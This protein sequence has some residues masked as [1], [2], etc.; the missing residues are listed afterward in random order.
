MKTNLYPVTIAGIGKYTPET[1]ITNN[2]LE[3]ILDTS[4]EWITTRS[5]IK[6]R[7]IVSGNETGA[8]LAVK[9]GREALEYAGIDP[10]EIDLIICATSIPDNLYPSTACEI[11]RDL[12]CSNAAAFDITAAC[13]GLIYGLNVAR[14]F[15]ASGIY[16]KVL[17]AS[18]DV[19]SRF[20]NWEDRGTCVLFGDGAGAMVLTRSEDEHDDIL[21][22]DIKA[23]GA[24]SEELKI[25][26]SGKNCPLVEPNTFK[27]PHVEMNGKEIYKFAINTVPESIKKAVD[28][29]GI[30]L[31][32]VDCF[33]LHQANIRIIESISSKLG[34]NREKFFVNL[35]KYGNTS[36][37]SIVIA[38]SEAIKEGYIKS[39]STLV[40]SG[41][42]A[43]L[44]W[45]TAVIKW[46]G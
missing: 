13:S 17:L 9:A 34:I 29:A 46:R 2:D 43:G 44:T 25:P 18:V 5:G 12:A 14:S 4:D 22:I 3:K 41:F 45:G 10:E 32:D 19:H 23:D 39:P 33:V 15:I 8:S 26:L 31:N 6:E 35:H 36:S 20:L 1:V 37:A 27:L 30:N 11:Q 21:F 42:G 24:K 40:L 28:S 16:K 38:L 7:R